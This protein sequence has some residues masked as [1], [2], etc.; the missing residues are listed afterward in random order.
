MAEIAS[1]LMR[2]EASVM[3]SGPLRYSPA[4]LPILEMTLAHHSEQMEAGRARKVELEIAAVAMGDLASMLANTPLGSV[5]RVEGFL[6][7]ARKGSPRIVLHLQR[8][9]R[10][11]AVETT[12]TA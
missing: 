5:L 4:G 1:N 2:L 3:A 12:M 7:H 8:V 9:Q 10:A 6:A 11:M